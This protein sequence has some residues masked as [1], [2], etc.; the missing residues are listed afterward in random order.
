MLLEK[1]KSR[2]GRHNFEIWFAESSFCTLHENN[3]S[4]WQHQLWRL[5]GCFHSRVFLSLFFYTPNLDIE[6]WLTAP[7][8]E[9][10]IC[11]KSAILGWCGVLVL[12]FLDPGATWRSF[13]TERK[14]EQATGFID[15]D[16][17]ESFL[18]LGRAKMQEVVSTLQVGT[19]LQMHSGSSNE[20]IKHVSVH[21]FHGILAHLVT[22]L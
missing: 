8:A 10:A 18:D 6:Y 21:S 9:T 12:I 22:V 11:A 17:I 20:Q 4:C 14:T 19:H 3:S 5:P 7:E 1:K 13:H 2:G 15:G 16:L